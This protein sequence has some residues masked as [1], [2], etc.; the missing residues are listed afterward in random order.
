MVDEI[1][2]EAEPI[3]MTIELSL[4]GNI[5]VNGP[6]DN[7]VLAYG[8][9]QAAQDAI[10]RHHEELRKNKIQAANGNHRI[11]NFIRGK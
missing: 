4:D 2:P 11:I 5:Q 7:K 8:L 6:I 9:L 1:K 10:F 3:R